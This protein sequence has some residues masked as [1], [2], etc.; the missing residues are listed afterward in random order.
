[1]RYS[2]VLAGRRVLLGGMLKMGYTLSSKELMAV[3]Y[4]IM[5]T[6]LEFMIIGG[7]HRHSSVH[8][9]ARF[10]PITKEAP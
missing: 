6:K 2:Q 8:Q 4:K 10:L 3:A 9:P 5:R 7:E 1:M